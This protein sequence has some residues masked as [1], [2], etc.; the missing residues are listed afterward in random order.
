M[1]SRNHYCNPNLRELHKLQ[2]PHS[3]IDHK[4]G[5]SEDFSVQVQIKATKAYPDPVSPPFPPAGPL[6]AQAEIDRVQSA[7]DAN[8]AVLDNAV[9][10]RN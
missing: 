2:H 1:A 3:K 6:N 7:Q 9:N 10:E 4:K 8:Q 5:S